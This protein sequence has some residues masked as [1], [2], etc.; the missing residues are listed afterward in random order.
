MAKCPHSFDK[1]FELQFVADLQCFCKNLM[2]LLRIDSLCFFVVDD[3]IDCST[4]LTNV[5]L[6][7]FDRMAAHCTAHGFST[8]ALGMC[9]KHMFSSMFLVGVGISPN[10]WEQLELRWT[11]LAQH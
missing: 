7:Y 6:M 5:K 4:Q 8:I 11:F 9:T 10:Y 2:F 1:H 3:C